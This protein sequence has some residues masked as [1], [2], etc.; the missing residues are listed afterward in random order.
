MLLGQWRLCVYNILIDR[1]R[2]LKSTSE[3]LGGGQDHVDQLL[4][5]LHSFQYG[6]C[7]EK[8]MVSLIPRGCSL[9]EISSRTL[10]V[11]IFGNLEVLAEI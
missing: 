8:E 6:I 9:F 11:E 5:T 1:I 4:L 2:A 3:Y 7:I 10:L